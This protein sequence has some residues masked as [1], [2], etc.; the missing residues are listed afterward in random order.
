MKEKK[1]QENTQYFCDVLDT[2]AKTCGSP[3]IIGVCPRS[4]AV[5]SNQELN[6]MFDDK[7]RELLNRISEISNVYPIDSEYILNA[8]PIDEYY[9]SYTDELAN[10]PYTPNFYSSIGTSL[11]RKILAFRIKPFKVI[12]LDCDNTLWKGICGEDGSQGVQVTEPFRMLQEFIIEQINSG[13]LA[14]LCSKN[15]E[16]DVFEVFNDRKDM[17]LK[18]DHFVA[19]RINWNSKSENLKYG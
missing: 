18:R 6:A 8:Y 11:F 5:T 2:F 16:E 4:P 9:D 12:V 15:N 10:I 17:I 1:L 3:L 7:E 13:M 14:C 19:W